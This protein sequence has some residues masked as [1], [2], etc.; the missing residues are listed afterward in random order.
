[1]SGAKI[2]HRSYGCTVMYAVG[3]RPMLEEVV[4]KGAVDDIG[5]RM[6]A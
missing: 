2:Y 1:M 3:E 6:L 5:V 4:P